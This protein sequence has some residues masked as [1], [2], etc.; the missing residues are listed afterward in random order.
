[1]LAGGLARKVQSAKKQDFIGR[2]SSH[3][4]ASLVKVWPECK[5]GEPLGN[6]RGVVSAHRREDGKLGYRRSSVDFRHGQSH[7]NQADEGT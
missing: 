7:S 6:P 4:K 1:M 5:G 3:I 2:A